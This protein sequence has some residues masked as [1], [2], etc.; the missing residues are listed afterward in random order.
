MCVCVCIRGRESLHTYSIQL[1]HLWGMC[2]HCVRWLK[3]EQRRQPEVTQP[4]LVRLRCSVISMFRAATQR[5]A[6]KGSVIKSLNNNKKTHTHAHAHTHR[7]AQSLLSGDSGRHVGCCWR[8]PDLLVRTEAGGWT[9]WLVEQSAAEI[10]SSHE[11]QTCF[12][13]T[14]YL[15]TGRRN[16]AAPLKAS[17]H[18]LTWKKL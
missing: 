17:T 15:W 16:R 5:S 12:Q 13:E 9:R 4:G 7:T 6:G 2:L 1:T 3:A 18:D 10:L 11:Y 14:I 8:F